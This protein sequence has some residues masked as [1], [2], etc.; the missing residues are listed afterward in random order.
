MLTPAHAFVNNAEKAYLCRSP[1]EH[2]GSRPSSS[3]FVVGIQGETVSLLAAWFFSR[4]HIFCR[5]A[6]WCNTGMLIEFEGGINTL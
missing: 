2:Y 5:E 4:A 3:A 6:S 1:C